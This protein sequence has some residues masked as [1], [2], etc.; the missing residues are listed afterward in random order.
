VLYFGTIGKKQGL[1]T[2]LSAAELLHQNKNIH[3]VICGEGVLKKE[4]VEKT[5]HLANL[6]W[7][8]TLNL[9]DF[10]SLLSIA[11]IHLLPRHV[12]IGDA[13]FP[14]K[15]V[16]MMVSGAAIV[17][18]ADPKSELETILEN[19]ARVIPPGDAKAFASAILELAENPKLRKQLGEAAKSYALTHWDIDNVLGTLV[20]E[21]ELLKTG[22]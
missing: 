21:V 3:F 19:R 12:G 1:E 8:D 16:T 9:A 10:R 20:Q 17:A 15:L 6:T 4:F 11:P 7:I 22:S 5:R 13:V 18:N 14:S 2:V